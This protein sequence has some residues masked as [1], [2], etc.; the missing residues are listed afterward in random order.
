MEAE[1]QITAREAMGL[2]A[3]VSQASTQWSV[4]YEMSKGEANVAMGR[5]YGQVHTFSRK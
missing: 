3:D 5:A 2:L 4:V 1:G